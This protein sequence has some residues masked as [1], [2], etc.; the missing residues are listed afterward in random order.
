M[1]VTGGNDKNLPSLCTAVSQTHT[2]CGIE[3][4]P[5]CSQN[6]KANYFLITLLEQG[7]IALLPQKLYRCHQNKQA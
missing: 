3:L 6:G 7:K 5:C 1:P 4:D 2:V